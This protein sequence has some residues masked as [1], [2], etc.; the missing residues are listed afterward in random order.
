MKNISLFISLLLLYACH[1]NQDQNNEIVKD[2]DHQNDK[3]S[4][5]LSDVEKFYNQNKGNDLPSQSKGLVS[6]GSLENGKLIPFKGDNFQ[7]FDT[8][9]YLYGRAFVHHKVKDAVLEAYE[10]LHKTLPERM[11]FIMET[12]NQHGGKLLPHKTHQNGLSVDFMMPLIKN[13]APYYDLAHI[14]TRHYMLKFDESGRPLRDTSAVIDFNTVAQ[15]LLILEEKACKNGLKIKKVIIKIEF[16][17][18]LFTTEYGKKLKKSKIYVVRGLTP[19]INELH[20]D[21]YHVDFELI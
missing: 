19:L 14:G 17:K 7:Y 4:E 15:H 12:S 13:G 5:E 16:K 11:F 18:H 3:L 2:K 8:S 20:D 6:N 21:H 1:S 9:S 10:E